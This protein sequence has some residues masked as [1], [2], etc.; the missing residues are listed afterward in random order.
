MLPTIRY[1]M[2]NA[3]KWTQI[4]ALYASRP[5]YPFAVAME[6]LVR[7]LDENGFVAAGLHGT[8][9]MFQLILGPAND[10]LNNPHL[11]IGPSGD[12]VQLTYEDGS[13]PPWS[14]LVGYD[15]LENRVEHFLVKRARWFRDNRHVGS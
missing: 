2:D 11:S 1:P 13:E 12:R 10:V 5:D 15:E 3:R 6:R 14:V 8:T 7:N 4:V 9:S